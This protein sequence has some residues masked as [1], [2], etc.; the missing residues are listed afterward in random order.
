MKKLLIALLI[1]LLPVFAKAANEV[2]KND[3]NLQGLW[4]L[5]N[6]ALDYT[7]NDN[8]LTGASGNS[9]PTFDA[10]DKVEGTHSCDYEAGDTE[11]H[12]IT[13]GD[14]TGLDITGNI[15]LCAWVK[16]KVHVTT[17]HPCR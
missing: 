3:A 4:L 12:E 11:Y 15:T 9:G 14:Q 13:D 7:G 17:K 1:I 2:Y 10:G 6:D 16:C 5:N 8:D